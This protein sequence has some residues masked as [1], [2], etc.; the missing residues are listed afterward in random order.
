MIGRNYKI[1]QELPMASRVVLQRDSSKLEVDKGIKNC[2]KW[3]WLERLVDGK[4][5]GQFIRKIDSRGVARCQLCQKDINY[6]GRGWISLEQ[7]M[8]KKLEKV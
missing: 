4:P 2:W 6:T 7:H 3:E 1:K 8:I 5:V